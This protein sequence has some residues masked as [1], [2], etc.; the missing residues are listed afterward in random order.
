MATFTDN[1]NLTKPTMNELADIRVLNGNMDTIDE[2]MH[3]SQV[4]IADAYDPT[5]TYDVDD[6]VMN[7]FLLY[8]CVTAVTTP[9]AFDPTKWE[10]T[11]AVNEGGE[12]GG[13]SA[14]LPINDASVLLDTNDVISFTPAT[15]TPYAGYGNCYYYK[16]GTRVHV[17][18]G[19]SGSNSIHY[20]EFEMPI[21]YRPNGGSFVAFGIG[22]NMDDSSVVQISDNKINIKCVAGYCLADME[23]DAV[24]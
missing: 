15:C 14:D 18:I 19:V 16:I 7:E 11:T 3:G 13:G 9:E 12:G 4:S 23:Y 24:G 2:I 21:G 5:L 17:H 22:A 10:R 1:Y 6:I 20:R 8:K